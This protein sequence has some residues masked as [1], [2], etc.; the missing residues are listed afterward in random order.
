[1][2]ERENSYILLFSLGIGYILGTVISSIVFYNLKPYLKWLEYKSIIWPIIV[3]VII[4][5]VMIKGLT[6]KIYHY[7]EKSHIS[8]SYQA[9]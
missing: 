5:Y 1:M 6:G 9:K 4:M 3:L 7:L 8:N 2:L